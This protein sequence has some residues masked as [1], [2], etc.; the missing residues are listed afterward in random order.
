MR[1]YLTVNAAEINIQELNRM[2]YQIVH[3]PYFA[4]HGHTRTKWQ[5][6]PIRMTAIDAAPERTE[7]LHVP[8]MGHVENYNKST[9]KQ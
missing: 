6:D 3:I 1:D 9:G 7:T 2:G 5:L 4:M 8:K